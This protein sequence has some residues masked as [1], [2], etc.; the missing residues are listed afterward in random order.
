MLPGVRLTRMDQ[1]TTRGKMGHDRL[2]DNFR[3]GRSDILL[4]TQMVAKGHDIANVTAVGILAADS[5]LNLPDFRASERSFALVMQAA[6]RAGRGSKHGRVVVQTYHPEHYALQAG[7]AQDYASFYNREILFRKQLNYPPYV[8][9]IKLTTTGRD[10]SRTIQMA[11]EMAVHLQS[12]FARLSEPVEIIGPFA[13][14]VSKIGDQFRVHILLRGAN[15]AAAKTIL[16]ESGIA[17]AR[18]VTID[19]DPLGML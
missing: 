3:A 14:A 19:V 8:Q 17:V 1:D 11:E 12:R 13:A 10:E 4:G 5:A 18:D 2:L 6:G 15:L 16:V 9:F 7:I